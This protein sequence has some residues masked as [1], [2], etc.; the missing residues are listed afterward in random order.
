MTGE[1]G[2]AAEEYRQ[3]VEER[4]YEV[5]RYPLGPLPQ[6]WVLP[7]GATEWQ[8]VGYTTEPIIGIDYGVPDPAETAVIAWPYRHGKTAALA[9]VE[10]SLT[11]GMRSL[12]DALTAGWQAS[13]DRRLRRLADDLGLWEPAVRHEFQQ[14]QQVLEG[15]GIGDGYGRLTIPQPVRP[16]VDTPAIRSWP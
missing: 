3:A 16:P 10:A 13:L 7:D 14:V 6:L 9:S 4:Y 11:G 15:A 8:H 2:S 12:F 5:Y 1:K